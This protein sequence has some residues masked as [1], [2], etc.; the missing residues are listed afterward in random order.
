M[1]VLS[2][3]HWAGYKRTTEDNKF[4]D[5]RHS[6]CLYIWIY[7]LH[8]HAGYHG[9]VAMTTLP[10]LWIERCNLV[11]PWNY[12]MVLLLVVY[13]CCSF[14]SMASLLIL[15]PRLTVIVFGLVSYFFF[16]S[17]SLNSLARILTYKMIIHLLKLDL[18]IL[19][20]TRAQ[21]ITIG[22]TF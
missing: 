12:Y 11:F 2:H 14:Q 10:P 6:L 15:S 8:I 20:L 7:I 22:L 19:Y 13:F 9:T 4:P 1:A 16:L 3:W 18:N 17:L 5:S 21:P